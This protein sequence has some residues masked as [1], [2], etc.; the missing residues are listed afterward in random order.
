M[1]FCSGIAAGLA[2][3]IGSMAPLPALAQ[4]WPEKPIRIIIPNS[5]GGGSDTLARGMIE[6]LT[7]ALGQPVFAENRGGANGIIGT[8]ACAKAAPDGHTLCSTSSGVISWNMVMRVKLPYH[9]LRDLAPV[10]QAGFFDFVLVVHPS[11]PVNSLQE[12]VAYAKSQPISAGC[13]GSTGALRHHRAHN[14]A[15]PSDVDI[16]KKLV[17]PSLLHD[18]RGEIASDR[19]DIVELNIGITFAE[20]GKGVSE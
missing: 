12:L 7:R 2:C 17:G 18:A 11:V 10:I 14:R 20:G 4:H 3:L 9:S 8:D 6:P 5:P 16:P 1:K 15:G 19:S 13:S